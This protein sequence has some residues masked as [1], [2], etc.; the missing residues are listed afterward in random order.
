MFIVYAVNK[1]MAKCLAWWSFGESNLGIFFTKVSFCVLRNRRCV[2]QLSVSSHVNC[3]I[4][5]GYAMGSLEVWHYCEG[6]WRKSYIWNIKEARCEQR[7]P[8]LPG[9]GLC[10]CKKMTM[11]VWKRIL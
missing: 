6:T 4:H 7:T 9:M 3:Y 10:E 8:D 2:S 5:G 11:T 1:S